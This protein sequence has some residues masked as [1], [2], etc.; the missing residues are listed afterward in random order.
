MQSSQTPLS[1]RELI[2]LCTSRSHDELHRGW[3]ELLSRYKPYLYSVVFRRMGR[4]R[5]ISLGLIL[6]TAVLLLLYLIPARTLLIGLAHQSAVDDIICEV[7]RTLCDNDFRLIRRFKAVDCERSFRGYLATITARIT[8]RQPLFT[9][10]AP[11]EDVAEKL[12]LEDNA[13]VNEHE[14]FFEQIVELLRRT[15]SKKE[16]HSECKI[17]MLNL[18]LLEDFS[19][20]MLAS[21]P[22][23]RMLGRR[24]VDN[25]INRTKTKLIDKLLLDENI[26]E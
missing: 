9:D 22:L 5:I 12:Y 10:I 20:K 18:Y 26:S 21:C 14:Q 23:F 7:I 3:S 4:R 11:L 19:T 6:L 2:A 15:A 17:L 13:P 8:D 16:K 1:V 24:M 25:T